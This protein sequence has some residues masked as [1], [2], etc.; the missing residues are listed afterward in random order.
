MALPAWPGCLVPEPNFGL[1]R[2]GRIQPQ[3]LRQPTMTS[4]DCSEGCDGKAD[5]DDGSN[6]RH[7]LWVGPTSRTAAPASVVPQTSS[8][9][10]R[11]QPRGPDQGAGASASA[12]AARTTRATQHLWTLVAPLV[13]LKLQ[14]SKQFS[15]KLHILNN[16]SNSDR[17]AVW[18]PVPRPAGCTR[19][20]KKLKLNE[21]TRWQI[22]GEAVE[23]LRRFNPKH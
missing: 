21:E 7:Y 9:E 2:S 23:E 20:D 10:Y 14:T 13:C 6:K 8:R 22:A 19:V 1:P 11:R 18:L 12:G 4:S 15:V 3:K 5:S 17:H 16:D